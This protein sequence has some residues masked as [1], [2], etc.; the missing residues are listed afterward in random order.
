M[1]GKV[2]HQKLIYRVKSIPV[3]H[4]F[5]S[6][7]FDSSL[8]IDAIKQNYTPE[9]RFLVFYSFEYENLAKELSKIVDA[10]KSMQ[11]STINPFKRTQN[12]SNENIIETRFERY[13]L[14]YN[15]DE[16]DKILYI[17]EDSSVLSQLLIENS[18]KFDVF[19]IY[20][21]QDI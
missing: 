14:V 20:L 13:G 17:G 4:V 18:G 16:Y 8:L 19:C 7:K 1:F 11:V 5:G 10:Y 12:I 2:I 21:T 3:H 9:D 6:K 15:S